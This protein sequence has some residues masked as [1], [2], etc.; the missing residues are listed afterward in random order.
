MNKL[1]IKLWE[2][3]LLLLLITFII[4]TICYDALSLEDF[5]GRIYE[6]F[7]NKGISN[8][9]I[10][11]TPPR[12]L[13]APQKITTTDQEG[14]FNFSGLEVGRYLLEVYQGPTLL[15]RDVVDLNKE[16]NKNIMLR[17]KN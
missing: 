13:K 17:A 2:G 5:S 11:I 4:L 16:T 10:K 1:L 15:Y 7:D 14:Q 6:A 12:T 8:L 3:T 9:V